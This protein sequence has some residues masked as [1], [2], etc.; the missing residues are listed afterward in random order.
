MAI[1][2]DRQ[3]QIG[4]K[5]TGKSFWL[6]KS[7]QKIKKKESPAEKM[8]AFDVRPG[9]RWAMKTF[10]LKVM[11]KIIYSYAVWTRINLIK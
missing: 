8:I 10:Y 9:T 11:R 1:L 4:V 6:T 7:Q 5:L 3:G 2:D